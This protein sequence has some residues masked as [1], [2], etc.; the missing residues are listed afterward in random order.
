MHN[1]NN[2]NKVTRQREPSMPG[3]GVFLATRRVLNTD[4]VLNTAG[5]AE[6][7]AWMFCFL[8]FLFFFC[9]G[10]SKVWWFCC[11]LINHSCFAYM[12]THCH[13]PSRYLL[14]P[15]N[16]LSLQNALGPITLIT[17]ITLIRRSRCRTLSAPRR[18]RQATR[19]VFKIQSLFCRTR[20]PQMHCSIPF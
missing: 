17:L 2:P 15:N 10:G 9:G 18:P 7:F 4:K 3:A 19:D 13:N 14:S 8:V 6:A 16:S 11:V 12:Q 5:K 1:P 20:T